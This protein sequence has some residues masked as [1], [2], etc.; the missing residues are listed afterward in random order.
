MRKFGTFGSGPG[1]GGFDFSGF[2]LKDLGKFWQSQGSRGKR[3]GSFSF[4]DLFGSGGFG[5]G[6]ILGDMNTR[7][8]R[9]QGMN[10]ERGKSIITAHVPLAEMQRY[11]TDLRSMTGGRGMF[12]MEF[13]KYETVPNHLAQEIIAAVQREKEEEN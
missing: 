5:L 8:A 3:T 12:T 11:T 9:V 13:L 4:E 10:S 7:R 2:D 1:M 6:D